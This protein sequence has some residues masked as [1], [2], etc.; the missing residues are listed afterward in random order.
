MA[1]N[2]CNN[3][4]V[5]LSIWALSEIGDSSTTLE[6]ATT[7]LINSRTMSASDIS[8]QWII[9]LISNEAGTCKL[10][11]NDIPQNQTL[12]ALDGYT[13]WINVDST[14]ITT[15]TNDLQI[16]CS[17]LTTPPVISLINKKTLPTT[18]IADYF[19]KEEKVNQKIVTVQLGIPCWGSTYRSTCDPD[20]TTYVLLALDKRAKSPDP[21]WLKERPSLSALQNAILYEL[22][23]QSSYLTALEST[24]AAAGYWTP[25]VHTTSLINS[26]IPDSETKSKSSTFINDQRDP[27]GCWPKPSDFCNVKSTAAAIYALGS[28][29]TA[30]GPGDKTVLIDCDQ[31]CEDSDGCICPSECDKTTI[32]EGR[33]CEGGGVIVN[34]PPPGSPCVTPDSCDGQK[35]AFGRCEDIPG[36]NCPEIIP[37]SCDNDDICDAAEDGSCLD[38]DGEYCKT[39]SGTAGTW[40][41][42]TGNCEVSDDTGGTG[43]TGSGTGTGGTSGS[44]STGGSSSEREKDE[45]SGALFWVLMIIALLIAAGGGLFLAYK[46]GLIKFKKDSKEKG[47]AAYT[48]KIAHK[49]AE[50]YKPRTH[51]N[52]GKSPVKKFLDKELNKSM[53]ELEKLLKK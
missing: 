40:D 11:N 47:I 31:R 21:T 24:Q 23:S 17:P 9:Q 44:G 7:W 15:T 22:T 48:P 29:T 37:G 52:A 5:A 27:S 34:G 26:L 41:F 46:K 50:P 49:P 20:I 2:S 25:N 16:D 32:G 28:S 36:D 45:K 13:P 14:M 19:I 10:I 35:D 1:S 53:D 4:N 8:G 33:T 12:N 3:K 39:S 43:G 6:D 51:R 38:C 30:P 18:N 42:N